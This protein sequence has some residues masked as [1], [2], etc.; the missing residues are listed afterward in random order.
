MQNNDEG[1]KIS[2]RGIYIG[3][4]AVIVG[5]LSMKLLADS[6]SRVY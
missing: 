4:A 6:Q 1:I 3:I 5:L 2:Y